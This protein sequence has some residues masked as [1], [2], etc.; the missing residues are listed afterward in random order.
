MVTDADA[1]V[2]FLDQAAAATLEPVASGMTVRRIALDSSTVDTRLVDWLLPKGTAAKPVAVQP[3]SAFNIIYSSGTTGAPKGIVMPHS[4][5]W[6]QLKVFST[7][8]YGTDTVTLLAIPLYSNMTQ[9]GL[10]PSL[11]MGGKVVLMAK[12]DAGRYLELAQLHRVTHSMLVP[13]QVQR[14]MQH[15]DFDRYDLSSFRV[16]SCASAPFSAALKADVLARW[17]GDLF[18]YYGMTEGGGV[19]ML[20]ARQRPDKLHTVGHPVPGSDMR[21]IDDHGHELPRGQAGEI[22]GRSPTMMIG[23]HKLPEMTAEVEWFDD[24]GQRFIRTG[25]GGRFDED[26]FL[27]LLDRKKDMIISGGFNVYPSD[28]ESVLRE[29]PDVAEVA[30]VGVPSIRWGESPVAFVVPRSGATLSTDA[31]LQWTNERVGKPQRLAAL[32][33]AEI[34]PRSDIGKILKRSLRDIWVAKGK[35][36]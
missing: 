26:G 20:D 31:L 36:L 15:P 18:E 16:K 3:D 30:V 9:S 27:V 5:R 17:P 2:L 11:G 29:H 8:G 25:D 13:V 23:Y 34:L 33:V 1:A 28:I 4:F 19:C 21:V 14:I 24:K 6:A 32:E 7:L 35:P 10:L 12:F 22:V